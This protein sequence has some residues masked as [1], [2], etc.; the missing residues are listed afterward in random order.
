MFPCE[1]FKISRNT[2][3]TE[4]LWATASINIIL[5]NYANT[6]YAGK[7]LTIAQQPYDNSV[8]LYCRARDEVFFLGFC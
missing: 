7:L 4:H 3:F 1:F 8:H 2:F 6:C 5:I